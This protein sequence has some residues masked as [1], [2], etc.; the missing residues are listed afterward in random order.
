M[1][2]KI[3]DTLVINTD[4]IVA[5]SWHDDDACWRVLV[6]GHN[7][8]TP[9][10]RLSASEMTHILESIELPKLVA[11]LKAAGGVQRGKQTR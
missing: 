5:A 6:S 11:I 8:S 10:I 2:C 3:N 4:H 9:V 7:D 1:L